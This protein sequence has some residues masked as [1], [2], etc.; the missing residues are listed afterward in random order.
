MAK[1]VFVIASL[2][3]T[4]IY[5]LQF[6]DTDGNTINMSSYEGKRILLV[7][8]ASGSSKVSQLTGLQQ[9]HQEYGDSVIIIAFPSNSFGNEPKTNT[10]IKLF[11]QSNYGVSFKIAAK[12]S[13]AG[14]GIQ[15][16]YNWLANISE[17]G[18]MNGVA[19]GDFQKFLI[20]KNGALIGVFSPSVLPTDNSI[21]EAITSN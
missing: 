17:N 6:T 9:L 14:T 1:L 13:V 11:C 3:L 21:I 10:E 19:G 4:S 7:N 5:T 8:I 20:D 16:I 12:G 2:F 18:N 15:T